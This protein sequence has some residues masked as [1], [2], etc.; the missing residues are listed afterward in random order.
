[1]PLPVIDIKCA[2][3]CTKCE[4]TKIATAEYIKALR[5]G[6]YVPKT[7]PDDQCLFMQ[8]PFL[9]A[10]TN[11]AN[12]Q[13]LIPTLVIYFAVCG[14]CFTMYPTRIVSMNLPASAFGLAISRQPPGPPPGAPPGRLN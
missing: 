14:E 3:K 5:D 11:P 4:S 7:V 6:G 13:G 2:D 1:M 9:T 12:L 8:F 10:L